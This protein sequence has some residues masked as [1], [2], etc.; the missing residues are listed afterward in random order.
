M[1]INGQL[2]R[3]TGSDQLFSWENWSNYLKY[4]YPIWYEL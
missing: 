2:Q 4:H 1:I 3:G